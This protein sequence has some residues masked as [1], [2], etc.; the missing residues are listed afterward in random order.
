MGGGNAMINIP[1]H[2]KAD[3]LILLDTT[4]SMQMELDSMIAAVKELMANLP[5]NQPLTMALV[6]FKDDVRV[7]AFTQEPKIL[8]KVLGELTVEGGGMCPEASAEALEI[9]LKHVKDGGTILLATDASPYPESNVTKLGDLIK[10]K[11][12]KF[13]ALVSGTCATSESPN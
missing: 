10:S 9:A 1:D 12:V 2:I 4:G 3:V 13:H 7:K 6:E 5:T 11:G 8:I